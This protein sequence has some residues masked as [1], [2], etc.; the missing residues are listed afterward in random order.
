MCCGS[1]SCV[2]LGGF[3]G[4]AVCNTFLAAPEGQGGVKCLQLLRYLRLAGAT[5]LCWNNL[6][7]CVHPWRPLWTEIF[8]CYYCVSLNFSSL[9]PCGWLHFLNSQILY[10]SGANLQHNHNLQSQISYPPVRRSVLSLPSHYT[11]HRVSLVCQ[12]PWNPTSHLSLSPHLWKE[13]TLC[14]S[15][16]ISSSADFSR[17]FIIFVN[18][19]FKFGALG[20]ISNLLT[21]CL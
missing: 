5:G 21:W 6:W 3:W 12:P 9:T 11:T 15:F 4:T 13:G 20:L 7:H 8:W 19:H 10:S 1:L 16:Q 17:A 2:C 14:K 18:K